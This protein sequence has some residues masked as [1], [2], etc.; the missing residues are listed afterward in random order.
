MG[1]ALTD[2]I[3]WLIPISGAHCSF[4]LWCTE[5]CTATLFLL[6][7]WHY[8]SLSSGSRFMWSQFMLSTAYCNQISMIPLTIQYYLKI[9]SY[10]YHLVINVINIHL[11]QSDHMEIDV[12]SNLCTTATLGT[13]KMWPLCRG[14]YEKDQW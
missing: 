1:L 13:W 12:Q 9:T 2:P 14:L 3:I 10:C 7:F 8:C 11:C 5:H 6:L 4:I